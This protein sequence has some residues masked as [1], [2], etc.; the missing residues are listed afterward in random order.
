MVRADNEK[1]VC[2][3][4]TFKA[5]PVL[6][7]QLYTLHGAKNGY[8]VPYV[9]ALLPDKRK[10]TYTRLFTQ[11]KVWLE[12]FGLE[13]FSSFLVDYEQGAF[14]AFLELFPDVNIEGCFF[15]FCKRLDFKVKQLG[16]MNKYQSDADFK[17]RI[18]KLAALAFIP[19]EDVVSVYEELADTFEDDEVPVLTYFERTWIGNVIGRRGRRSTPHF[20]LKMWNVVGRHQ[21]GSTC[22]NNAIEAFNHKFNSLLS[23]HHPSLWTLI[24]SL[25]REQALTENTHVHINRGDTKQPSTKEASRNARITNI[26]QSYISSDPDKTFRGIA[27]NYM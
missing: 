15:H 4:G 7:S 17:M 26:V 19:L 2:G 22:T 21:Q 11:I 12:P 25:R 18:K 24:K 5:T 1:R 27:F 8:T 13:Q 14:K 6:R 9:Y 16:L 23:C 10:E 3:D 20:P